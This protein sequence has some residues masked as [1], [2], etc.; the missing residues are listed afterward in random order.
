MKHCKNC[1]KLC[2]VL[3]KDGLC[4]NCSAEIELRKKQK[5]QSDKIRAEL[6]IKNPSY[7]KNC[8]LLQSQ[9][10]LLSKVLAAKEKYKT[11]NDVY[12]A[13]AVYE[14]ALIYSDP[15][16]HSNSHTMFLANLY[17]QAEEYDKAWA[18]LNKLLLTNVGLTYKIRK[19]QC[20]ILKKEKKYIDAMLM[21]ALSYL[22]D[23]KWSNSFRVDAF[24][25][26]AAPIAKK[27]NWSNETIEQLASCIQS[28]VNEKDYDESSLYD[29]MEKVINN[30]VT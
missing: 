20:R 2:F 24:V 27:L 25:K 15:P 29:D 30:P 5:E 12:A 22:A 19:E 6:L 14:Q 18:Y 21:L 23:S 3:S 1:G 17:I 4:K 11:D 9:N 13:I 10:E 16:L 8:E 7:A 28:H 26:E